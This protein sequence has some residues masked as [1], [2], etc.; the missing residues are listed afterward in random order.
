MSRDAVP[1]V[2]LKPDIKTNGQRG[3]LDETHPV[4]AA[5]SNVTSSS[6]EVE[7]LSSSSLSSTV[8]FTCPISHQQ[9]DVHPLMKHMPK[10]RV[11]SQ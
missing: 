9:S 1:S 5:G 4:F 3:T 7:L 11:S 10:A 8:T 6:Q 2:F